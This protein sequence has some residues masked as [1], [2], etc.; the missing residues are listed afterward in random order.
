MSI[1]TESNL[2]DKLNKFAIGYEPLFRDFE[3][4]FNIN[5]PSYPPYNMISKTEDNSEIVI[6]VAIA[7]FKK[8]QITIEKKPRQLT[9]SG[10]R[11]ND[12]P[13]GEIYVHWLHRGISS[14]DFSLSWSIAE[15]VEVESAELED[16][17]LSVKLLRIIPKED[18][19]K[20]IE[21]KQV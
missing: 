4:K 2:F 1:L 19:P 12:E 14:R 15:N 7:G 9:I 10:S 5:R 18:I 16:G 8:E 13:A 3:N 20:L 6:E 17:I 11:K 21:I